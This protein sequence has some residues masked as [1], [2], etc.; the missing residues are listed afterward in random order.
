MYYYDLSFFI[1]FIVRTCIQIRYKIFNIVI[2]SGESN[3]GTAESVFTV[4][5]KQFYI[6]AYLI[7]ISDRNPVCGFQNGERNVRRD[8]VYRREKEIR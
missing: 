6:R 5:N 2:Y 8:E 3:L 4:I 1:R 7:T